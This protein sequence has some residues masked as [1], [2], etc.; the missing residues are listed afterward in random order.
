MDLVI[1]AATQAAAQ[2]QQPS[3]DAQ[4]GNPPLAMSSLMS[5]IALHSLR[6]TCLTLQK[7]LLLLG[8]ISHMGS[9]GSAPVTAADQ[10]AMAADLI[11]P[12][13]TALRSAAAALWLCKTPASGPVPGLLASL[14]SSS[15][16]ALVHNSFGAS[17]SAMGQKGAAAYALIK[18]FISTQ[19]PVVVSMQLTLF[20][21]A[22]N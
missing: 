17:P 19:L 16:V 7:L 15:G 22:M 13:A 2:L 11:T 14:R 8:Y 1:M 20:W 3:A 21:L 9:L 18:P 10:A 6:A 4:G 5:N 12:L